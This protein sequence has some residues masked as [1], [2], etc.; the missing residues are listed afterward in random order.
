MFF[1][2]M[3]T[4]FHEQYMP[5]VGARTGIPAEEETSRI[6]RVSVSVL[7]GV[8]SLYIPSSSLVF[9]SF[10][11][12]VR[13]SLSQRCRTKH[14]ICCARPLLPRQGLRR[15]RR[16]IAADHHC[17]VTITGPSSSQRTSFVWSTR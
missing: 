1:W 17:D 10:S 9:F 8:L 11:L 5:L 14:N 3:G 13:R 4:S 2:F 15:A 12:P 16:E 6:S 7:R